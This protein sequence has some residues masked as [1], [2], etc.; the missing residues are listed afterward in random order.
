[1]WFENLLIDDPNAIKEVVADESQLA[2]LID[3]Y[4][5]PN[6][7]TFYLE[8]PKSELRSIGITYEVI[9]MSAFANKR[10]LNQKNF[11]NLCDVDGWLD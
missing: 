7:N 9:I 3:C 8:K 4:G 10:S 6:R 1:M 11:E 2:I 5:S